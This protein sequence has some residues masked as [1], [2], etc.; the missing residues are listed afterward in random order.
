MKS[1][2]RFLNPLSTSLTIHTLAQA[3]PLWLQKTSRS[4]CTTASRLLCRGFNL[5]LLSLALLLGLA[6]PLAAQTTIGRGA[7][8]A[9]IDQL[10]AAGGRTNVEQTSV[11]LG[12]GTRNVTSFV[13]N[14]GG[15]SGSLTPFLAVELSPNNYQPVWVG[16]TFTPAGTG[17]QTINYTAGTQ[18]FTLATSANVFA[19]FTQTAPLVWLAQPGVSV[20]DHNTT[21]M[22]ATVG[23]PLGTISNPDIPRTY[24]FQINVGAPAPS[25]IVNTIQPNAVTSSYG[26]SL[27]TPAR[28]INQSGLSTGYTEGVTTFAAATDSTV[29]H[30]AL[31][32]NVWY[33]S[34]SSGNRTVTY[35][36]GASYDVRAFG[37]WGTGPEAITSFNLLA[38]DDASFTTSQ[39]VAGPLTFTNPGS[40]GSRRAQT[41]TFTSVRARYFRLSVLTQ[42]HASVMSIGEVVFGGSETV[43]TATQSDVTYNSAI[44]GGNVIAESSERGIVWGTSENPTTSNNKVQIGSGTGAF[45]QLVTGLPSSTTIHVRAY[46]I[47]AAGTAYGSNISF[48]TA[49]SAPTV[50]SISPSTGSTAGGTNVTITG[51]G[52]T[53][54][55]GVTIGGAAATDVVVNSATTITATTPAGT[56]GTASVLVTTPAG[57][58]AANTLFTYGAPEIAAFRGNSTAVGD[59]LTD[60]TG[61]QD[62]LKAAPGSSVTRD[63][64]IQNTGTIPLNLGTVT[65]TGTD[66]ADFDVPQPAST[67][68]A[69]GETTSITVSFSP[70]TDGF[71]QAQVLIASDDANEN[72]F[73]INVSGTGRTAALPNVLVIST[74]SYVSQV[75]AA[76]QS[77]GILGVVDTVNANVSTPS[78]ATLMNY[79][80]VLYCPDNHPALDAASLG[81]RLSDYVDL[82]GGVVTT[83]GAHTPVLSYLRGHW[84]SRS[85]GALTLGNQFLFTPAPA[86][87]FNVPAHPVFEAVKSV[88]STIVDGGNLAPGATQLSHWN[89]ENMKPAVAI[90][91]AVISTSVYPT[92]AHTSPA[93]SPTGDYL[94]LLANALTVTADTNPAPVLEPGAATISAFTGASTAPGDELTHD[95]GTQD[96][97]PSL[98]GVA[99]A[100]RTITVQ[101]TGGDI[102]FLN[103]ITLTGAGAA[104]FTLTD[105]QTGV[106]LGGA[107]TTF[108]VRATPQSAGTRNAVIEIATNAANVTPFRIHVTTPAQAVIAPV[109]IGDV[110]SELAAGFNRGAVRSVDGSGLTAGAHTN[111]ADGTMWLSN[112]NFAAPNDPLPAVITFDLGQLH[113]LSS[114]H[115]WNYNEA[116]A[117]GRGARDVTVSVAENLA[118]PFAPA[119]SLVLPIA[120]GLADYTGSTL[121]FTASEARYVRFEIT[122]NHGGDLSFA[123]LSEVKFFGTRTPAP[124][125]VVEQPSGTPLKQPGVIAWGDS[126]GGRTVV[127][128]GLGRV[129]ALAVGTHTVALLE[130][131]TVV[132]WG[133]NGSGQATVPDGLSDVTAIAASR[134]H[135]LALKASGQVEGWGRDV[136]GQST[137]PLAAQSGVIAIAAGEEF[138][139][140][141]KSTGEVIAWGDNSLGQTAVPVAAQSGVIAIA[142]GYAHMVALK[143]DGT[144]VAWGLNNAGQLNIPDG[145]TGVTKIAA[146]E[147]VTMALKSDGTVAAWG[148]GSNGQATVP[149][150]LSDVVDISAGYQHS[151]ALKADGTVVVWGRDLEGQVAGAA[152]VSGVTLIAKGSGA[153]HIVA[154]QPGAEADFGSQRLLVTSTARTY[155]LK[156]TGNAPLLISSV[157]ATGGQAADFI[158]NTTGMA[159]TVAGGDETTFTLS[160]RPSA[161]GARTAA[162]EITTN[163][164]THPVFTVYVEG[165]GVASAIAISGNGQPITAGDTIPDLADHTSFGTMDVS[166]GAVT[167]SFTISNSGDATLNLS[168][169]PLVSITGA[170]AADFA[171][172]TAPAASVAPAGQT[173][174]QIQ[175]TPSAIGTR[176]A[177]VTIASD[178]S[179]QPSFSFAIS[180]VVTGTVVG[181][182]DVVLTNDLLDATNNLPAEGRLYRPM[183]GVINEDGFTVFKA[184]GTVGS[185]GLTAGND[186]LLLT[187]VT[188]SLQVIGQEGMS[189][190]D[191]STIPG[192]FNHLLLTP[193]GR[194]STSERFLGASTSTDYGYL[195]SEN[196]ATLE[197]LSREGDPVPDG[198]VFTGHTGRC[199]ADDE[200]RLY[201]PGTLRGVAATN[202]SGIW[203]DEEGELSILALEGDDIGD[204]TGDLAWLGNF[205]APLSAA[206]NGATFV[207]ALQNNPEKP[208]QKT[209]PALNAAIVSIATENQELVARKGD[210]IPAVG[211][212]STFSAVSR[213]SIG[214]HA[215][216]SLLTLSTTA[217]VVA[218]ANDQVLMAEIGGVKHVVAR[219][220][221]TILT[222]TLKPARFGSFYMTSSGE[223]IYQ[224]WLAGTGVSTAN[225]S[226]LC[227]WTVAGGN[228]VL[229]REG[230]VATGTGLNY[231]AFQGL[232]VSPGGAVVL[233]S[234][235]S[236]GIV[237]M[238]ALPGAALS[239]AVRTG[240]TTTF[241]GTTRGILSLGIYQTSTGAGGGGGGLGAAINDEG[242]IFTVL[243]IGNGQYVARVYRP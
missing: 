185:G 39:N 203:Y 170:N 210:V 159:G 132:A 189:L 107:S 220:N 64:T 206:G 138:S 154:Y 231:G 238:R 92:L 47:S 224:A 168:G 20:T 202:N 129:K 236:S 111:A 24:A 33:A 122:S 66:A 9:G 89:N 160:F 139:A 218:A 28:T 199:V 14:S 216:I 116:G 184:M 217:P 186:S 105:T 100:T 235:L 18:Q 208:T 35:D 173:T 126:A 37:M 188:G 123:G 45:S 109:V 96:L 94:R 243:S 201:F 53:G 213:S 36:L 81:N 155:H 183:P 73:R 134:W 60:N 125:L 31:G 2:S 136:Y 194:S 40:E 110:S 54:A 204:L 11:V 181:N 142:A 49:A 162:I 106:L 7:N 205:S 13:F 192:T 153:N 6:M 114:L 62:F 58:N 5:A 3:L 141:L 30:N 95:S 144:L 8:L 104:D 200:E 239:V 71:K 127:P 119:G 48:T 108:T 164:L 229:A 171:L 143:A 17:I 172:I 182:T 149:M 177:L 90:K 120:T 163:D 22:T 32:A 86:M 16:P 130:D 237:L 121:A 219:E 56:A 147:G 1:T 230:S 25:A 117:V 12:A 52:F 196:A 232:S 165:S 98:Q 152:A 102:L 118:G 180:A 34:D 93:Y 101:N 69:T 195:I 222:G 234:T 50:A 23:A 113:D 226:V 29:L 46:A 41:W 209:P 215:F 51:T 207:A 61:V 161:L 145:L 10:D 166:A 176:S 158:L 133:L 55:T 190:P 223:V 70:L 212:L 43:T 140:V 214:D 83:A 87:A 97:G 79:D 74:G 80:A 15:T 103:S 148:W 233:Q 82:G 75:A 211:K 146:G 84:L 167:R 187:D 137:P 67:V 225:D 151:L 135:T 221:T 21:A 85:R 175:F 179:A 128:A 27:G 198:G 72:P 88:N 241:N 150:G 169:P 57:T 131:S 44:L 38:S 78:L 65:V 115:V 59:A 42:N 178:A 227:R 4:R 240:T 156:N 77:T 242:A 157:T 174:F 68:L 26:N 99:G 63:F 193:G 124:E 197:I 228:V 19:G 191:G 91:G 76:L 112:G